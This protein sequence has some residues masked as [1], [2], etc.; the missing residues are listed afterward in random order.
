MVVSPDWEI[1]MRV[2]SLFSGIGGIELGFEAEGYTTEWF[3]EKDEYA[4]AIKEYDRSIIWEEKSMHICNVRIATVIQ[5]WRC[6]QSEHIVR[7]VKH[8]LRLWRRFWNK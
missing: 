1:A 7:S 5:G 4:K 2:G 3:V 8:I 6:H